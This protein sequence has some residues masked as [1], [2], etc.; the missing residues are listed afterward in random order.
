VYESFVECAE[1]P[2]AN[3]LTSG[4]YEGM[5]TKCAGTMD[6]KT[7]ESLLEGGGGGK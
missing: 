3:D 1:R 5:R 4:A 2:S 6:Y 7:T